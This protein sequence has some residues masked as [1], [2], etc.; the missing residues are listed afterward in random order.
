MKEQGA[1]KK[2]LGDSRFSVKKYT[3]AYLLVLGQKPESYIVN[4]LYSKSNIAEILQV[5]KPLI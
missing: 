3:F 5:I 1:Q 2:S 4:T